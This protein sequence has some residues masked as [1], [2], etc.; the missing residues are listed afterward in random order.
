MRTL[1]HGARLVDGTITDVLLKGGRIAAVGP[2]PSAD[3][4][5]EL[6]G[7]V[8]LPSFVEPHAHLDKALTV[9]R[10]VNRTGDLLGAIRAM[11]E[12]AD[13]FTHT[14]F[15]RRAD[16]ALRIHLA[17]GTTVVRS[18]VN[19]GSTFG[20]RALAALVEVR[21]AWR[22]IVDLELV[23]LI[24]HPILGSAGTDLKIALAE[25]AD[26]AG[27]CPHLDPEPIGAVGACLDIAGEAGVPLDLH[28]DETLNPA[29]LTLE[30]LADLVLRTGFEHGVTAS[31]CVSLGVQPED[32]Q[33]RVAEKVA[34][35]GVAIVAL[36]QTNLYLQ[37]R[38]H[39]QS[40]PRG[41]T[42]VRPLLAAGA[43]VAAGG[44]NLRDAFHPVGRGDAL[45]VGALMVTDGHLSVLDALRTLTV[46]G[47]AALGRPA[48]AIE[49]GAPADLVAVRACDANEALGAASPDRF[50]WSSGNLV[51]RTRID[52]Q[53]A[54]TLDGEVTP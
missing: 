10:S 37:G 33:R 43:T 2:E 52:T 46:G 14:D 19:I 18:H 16:A 36:P 5:V 40:T 44:D 50:V 32:V 23:A 17:Y 39:P 49:P 8:L 6:A 13:G 25:G 48:V 27:G 4:T 45:E 47:R 54:T 53:L 31:H 42:A 20:L 12:I 30:H 15:V 29:M 51:A 21:E 26:V 22:G 3:T 7:Y 28:T 35:A 1:L 24:G 41:L 9:S 34:A 11:N 38:E